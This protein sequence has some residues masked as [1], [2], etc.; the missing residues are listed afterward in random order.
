MFKMGEKWQR[1]FSNPLSRDDITG[2]ER[3]AVVIGK[4]R[5]YVGSLTQALHR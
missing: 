1:Y 5:H 4:G 3:G 2:G